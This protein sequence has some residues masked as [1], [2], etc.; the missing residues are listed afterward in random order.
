M[1]GQSAE[2]R[3]GGAQHVI[4]ALPSPAWASRAN[5][6]I[7]RGDSALMDPAIQGAGGNSQNGTEVGTGEKRSHGSR[8]EHA[9]IMP[10]PTRVRVSAWPVAGLAYPR[11]GGYAKIKGMEDADFIARL[12]QGLYGESADE[13]LGTCKAAAAFNE[14]LSSTDTRAQWLQLVGIH[15]DTWAKLVGIARAEPLYNPA[16]SALLPASF[17]TLALLSRCSRRDF[18]AAIKEGLISPK[19]SYRTLAAWRK[20]R[21]EQ[22]PSRAPVLHLLPVVVAYS[23]DIDATEEVG[24]LAAL[25]Q[26]I[27]AQPH[28]AELIHLNGWENLQ[29]QA[30]TQ[31]QKCR[32]EEAR[33]EVN[34]LIAPHAVTAEEL[35]KPLGELKDLCIDFDT[36]EWIAVY[37]LKNAHIALYGPTKQQRYAARTRLQMSAN[38]GNRLASEL[39]QALLGPIKPQA[40]I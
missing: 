20:Q 38:N 22:Q 1:P 33:E 17:S 3:H 13:I 35:E 9:P 27:N 26:A 37:V 4:Q 19:L 10:I 5:A 32:L 12:Q 7:S 31:W 30:L 21:E 11:R 36:D 29:E 2:R 6:V 16:L 23:A 34:R 18:D 8:A 28:K 14:S 25:Q 24:M 15:P 39:I 40:E